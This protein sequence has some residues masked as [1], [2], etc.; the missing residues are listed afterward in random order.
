MRASTDHCGVVGHADTIDVVSMDLSLLHFLASSCV[1]LNHSTV[2]SASVNR[3][4]ER[5]PCE[6]SESVVRVASY[7]YHGHNFFISEVSV[8]D[9]AEVVYSDERLLVGIVLHGNLFITV[10][11]SNLVGLE[12]R[13]LNLP[14]KLS[15]SD[16]VDLEADSSR[17]SNQVFGVFGNINRSASLFGIEYSNSLALVSVE[18]TYS[19]II[20]AREE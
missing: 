17:R 15:I 7:F 1:E 16:I 20:G 10:R 5:S 18:H 12:S 19:T 2:S 11:K 8:H 13:H 4:I 14:D 6:G 9:S 3:L